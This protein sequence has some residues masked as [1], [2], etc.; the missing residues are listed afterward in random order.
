LGVSNVLATQEDVTESC[1]ELIVP[2]QIKR[3][4]IETRLI[5]GASSK[6]NNFDAKLVYTIAK[7]YTWYNDLKSG[8]STSINDIAKAESLPASE[9]S[10]QLRLAF[11]APR[12]VEAILR[13]RQPVGL[14]AKTLLRATDIPQNWDRQVRLWGFA[15]I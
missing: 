7:A 12:I 10:R 4:G 6:D 5:I 1:H 3:R 9:V 8:T 15:E 14:T 2:W 13:G 11:L